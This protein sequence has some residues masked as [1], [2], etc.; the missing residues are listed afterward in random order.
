[1]GASMSGSYA[2]EVP[3]NA[4]RRYDAGV[5][6]HHGHHE[7]SIKNH[8]HPEVAQSV[9]GQEFRDW[10]H[11]RKAINVAWAAH[12]DAGSRFSEASLT[13][14]R[15]GRNPFADEAGRVGGRIKMEYDHYREIRDGAD[16]M[17]IGNLRLISP[18][19]HISKIGRI[20]NRM[21]GSI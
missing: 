10:N 8:V 19:A 9:A 5:A 12:P 2:T 4:S 21:A 6:S 13:E 1:M 3:S 14:M 18:S 16:P 17:A 11:L 20:F 7:S 15:Q